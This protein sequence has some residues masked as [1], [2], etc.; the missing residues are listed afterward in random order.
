MMSDSFGIQIKA[1]A[2]LAQMSCQWLLLENP[3]LFMVTDH[4]AL[5]W[6]NDLLSRDAFGARNRALSELKAS[7]CAEDRH[8]RRQSAAYR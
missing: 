3:L 6:D 4:T 8:T 5:L 2:C 1:L 7:V